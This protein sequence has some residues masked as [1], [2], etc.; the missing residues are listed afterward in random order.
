MDELL[1][2]RDS[3]MRRFC[4]YFVT[5]FNQK[6]IN[7]FTQFI[8]QAKLKVVKTKVRERMDAYTNGEVIKEPEEPGKSDTEQKRQERKARREARRLKKQQQKLQIQG[9]E[10][11]KFAPGGLHFKETIEQSKTPGPNLYQQ[12]SNSQEELMLKMRNFSQQGSI[13]FGSKSQISS[14]VHMEEISDTPGYN[15]P[16]RVEY[17]LQKKI[18]SSKGVTSRSSKQVSMGKDSGKQ[19]KGTEMHI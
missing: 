4:N 11:S 19:L 15:R 17:K 14:I 3:K 13:H 2:Q 7:P 12:R 1:A 16:E 9:E 6:K 5:L 18:T 10:Q 8:Q